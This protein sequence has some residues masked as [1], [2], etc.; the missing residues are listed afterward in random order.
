MNSQIGKVLKRDKFS[1]I[2]S[3]Q[4]LSDRNVLLQLP[5]DDICEFVGDVTAEMDY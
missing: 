4:L 2:A 1:S 5:Y 3:V